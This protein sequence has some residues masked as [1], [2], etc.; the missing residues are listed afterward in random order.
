MSRP[1]RSAAAEIVHIIGTIFVITF[2]LVVALILLPVII[3]VKI[4]ERRKNDKA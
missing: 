4:Y 1:N 2:L 3:G